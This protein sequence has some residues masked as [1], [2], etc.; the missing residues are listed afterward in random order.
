MTQNIVLFQKVKKHY[1][2]PRGNTLPSSKK[3]TITLL[4]EIKITLFQEGPSSETVIVS[5]GH[6]SHPRGRTIIWGGI[7][8]SR[9]VIP[10]A[11][12]LELSALTPQN[13]N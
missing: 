13:P 3:Q 11:P 1:P 6:Y 7:F 2:F 10:A 5:K 8:D 4:Q 9:N 12:S